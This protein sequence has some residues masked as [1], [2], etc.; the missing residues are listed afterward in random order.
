MSKHPPDCGSCRFWSSSGVIPGS[1]RGKQQGP[2]K[3]HAPQL[4]VIV[5]MTAARWP[6]TSELDWCGDWEDGVTGDL[7]KSDRT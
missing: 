5:G 2:C 4:V 3:R 7:P 6:H 1:E